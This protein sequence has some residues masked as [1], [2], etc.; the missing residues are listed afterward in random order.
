M[1]APDLHAL[2]RGDSAAWDVAF[3]W[4]W[5]TAFE[6]VQ[7]K[8]QPFLPGDIEDVAI[9]VLEQLVEKVRQVKQVHELKPLTA[10]IAHNR[11][12]SR[13]REHFAAKRGSGRT[14]SLEAMQNEDSAPCDPPGE[15]SALESLDQAELAA[16]LGQLLGQLKPEQR[17]IMVDFHLHGLSYE[18]ISQKH[19]VPEGTIGVYLKRGLESIR[20]LTERHLRLLK[21]LAAFL[22]C[23]L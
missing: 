6:V 8:L 13:L 15:L 5:P 17:A 20:R 22:R 19:R 11:A 4:L 2:Q 9:E 10:S 16:L 12:V 3:D 7:L 1:N 14:E 18:Q 21:E 23:L